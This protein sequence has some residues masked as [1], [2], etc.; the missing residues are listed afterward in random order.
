MS[1]RIEEVKGKDIPQSRKVRLKI[2]NAVTK[3]LESHTIDKTIK[4]ELILASENVLR[5]LNLPLKYQGYTMV[6]MYNALNIE[7]FSEIPFENRLLLLPKCLRSTAKCKGTFDEI[8]L[9]CAGCGNCV[10]HKFKSTGEKLG[11][12]VLIAEGTPVVVRILLRGKIRA[13][14]GVS[15]LTTLEKVFYKLTKSGIVGYA[16]PLLRNGCK[17]TDVDVEEVLDSIN[18]KIQ[19]PEPRAVIHELKNV[20]KLVSTI[21]D[22]VL[23]QLPKPTDDVSRIGTNWVLEG[24][25]R[26]RPFLTVATFSVLT[27]IDEIPEHVLKIALAVELFHKA[28]LVHDDIEDDDDTRYGKPTLHRQHTMPIALN[29]GDYLLGVGYNLLTQCRH[30]LD[31]DICIRVVEKISEAH[32]SL[33]TAQGSELRWRTNKDK[34]ISVSDVLKIYSGKTA[35]AFETAI[36]VGLIIAKSKDIPQSKISEYSTNLGIAFQILD[37]MSEF[38]EGI[39][40]DV[41]KGKPTILYALAIESCTRV[42]RKKIQMLYRKNVRTATDVKTIFSIYEK[43]EVVEKARRIAELHC[44]RAKKSIKHLGNEDLTILLSKII[45][46]IYG[47]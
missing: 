4:T 35:K 28:S 46:Y 14:L 16:V 20:E 25:K 6:M 44:E 8:E 37:D 5:T 38:I 22:D 24:G 32:I 45:E 2:K 19:K 7:T 36:I 13:I 18:L 21:F 31:T 9:V 3:Y 43:Y 27:K 33:A 40:T 39:Q 34:K 42:E 15:C 47:R 1:I 26:L 30:S 17:D 11:Y 12:T 23:T 29:V 41:I 10:L